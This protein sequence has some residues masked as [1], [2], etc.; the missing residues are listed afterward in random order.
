MTKQNRPAGEQDVAPGTRVVNYLA[1]HPHSSAAEIAG[2]LGIGRST[3]TRLLRE[4]DRFGYV[5]RIPGGHN[6]HGRR[7]PD[8][9]VV[10]EPTI[11]DGATDAASA[12][13]DK[14]AAADP[15]PAPERL[16]T[17][18]TTEH[19][20]GTTRPGGRLQRGQLATIVLE[21]L[22]ANSGADYTA[23]ALSKLLDRSSGAIANALARMEQAGVVIKTNDKPVRYSAKL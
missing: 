21:H 9:F 8:R 22:R 1:D 14:Q 7:E 11:P 15:A 13:D 20:D 4:L 19:S 18:T 3:A 2:G 5:R 23:P 10:P 12:D 6:M 17:A 16:D